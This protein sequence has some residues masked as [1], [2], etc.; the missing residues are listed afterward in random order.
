MFMTGNNSFIRLFFL[1]QHEKEWK[2][3]IYQKFENTVSWG[4]S[5]SLQISYL[6][7]NAATVF[8]AVFVSFW[9]KFKATIII[10]R[11]NINFQKSL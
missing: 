8:F 4:L 3:E 9:G 11:N 5:F 6:F 2:L 10:A 1:I 7:D